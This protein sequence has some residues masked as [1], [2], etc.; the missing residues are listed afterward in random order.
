MSFVLDYSGLFCCFS[1]VKDPIPI[2]EIERFN[3]SSF[4]TE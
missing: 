4:W 3:H 1:D 2:I